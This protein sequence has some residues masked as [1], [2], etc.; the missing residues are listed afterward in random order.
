MSNNQEGFILPNLVKVNFKANRSTS[1]NIV[2]TMPGQFDIVK[3]ES[4]IG[5]PVNGKYIFAEVIN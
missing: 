3:R 1:P 5:G 4:F 2:I